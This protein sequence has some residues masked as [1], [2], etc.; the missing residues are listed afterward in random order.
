M[1]QVFNEIT[2]TPQQLKVLQVPKEALVHKVLLV[3]KVLL[4]PL[5]QRHCLS[6]KQWYPAAVA[7]S[8]AW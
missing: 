5:I 4:V 8:G 6:S 3:I 7:A 2:L 1:I